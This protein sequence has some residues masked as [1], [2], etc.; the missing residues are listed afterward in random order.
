MAKARAETKRREDLKRKQ[1][2][3]EAKAKRDKNTERSFRK[4]P[5]KLRSSKIA[6]EGCMVKDDWIDG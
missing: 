5:K 1:A 3:D 6:D 2:T 4:V